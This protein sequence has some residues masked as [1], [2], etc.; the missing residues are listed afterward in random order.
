MIKFVSVSILILLF[1]MPSFVT[2]QKGNYRI[3]KYDL[4]LVGTGVE[5]SCLTTVSIYI[6][7]ATKVDEALKRAAVYG[8]IFKGINNEKGTDF[9]PPL[10]N[11]PNIEQE[12]A[13][14]F[15]EFFKAGGIYLQYTTIVDGSLLVTKIGKKEYRITAVVSIQKD[16]LRKYL[17]Q[18]KVIIG[19]SDI[20]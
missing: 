14:F 17:E 5:G 18:E 11:N 12:K 8:V 7:K 6:P 20:F 3:P 10:A 4:S 19:F 9:H 13:K 16:L 1:C 2:A 15:N